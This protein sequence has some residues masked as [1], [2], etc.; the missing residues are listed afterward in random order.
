MTS[1]TRHLTRRGFIGAGSGLGA[2]ALL[3]GS[4]MGLAMGSSSRKRLALVGT[5]I[6]GCKFWGRFVQENYFIVIAV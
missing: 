5:G 4:P 3:A 6:R 2:A 1:K